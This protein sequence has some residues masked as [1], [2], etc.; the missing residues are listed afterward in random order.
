[1][2]QRQLLQE[3]QAPEAYR[4]FAVTRAAQQFGSESEPRRKDER[5]D[6]SSRTHSS[7]LAFRST[8]FPFARAAFTLFSRSCD[9]ACAGPE[10]FTASANTSR[11]SFTLL[12]LA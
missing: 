11:A 5:D 8:H 12:S 6:Y 1:M 7:V 2:A 10:I 4:V 9:M 3:L